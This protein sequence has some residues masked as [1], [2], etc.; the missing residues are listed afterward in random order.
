MEELLRETPEAEEYWRSSEAAR[1]DKIQLDR[2]RRSKDGQG[3]DEGTY[4]LLTEKM[5]WELAAKYTDDE[6]ARTIAV[7]NINMIEKKYQALIEKK[8]L[9]EKRRKEDG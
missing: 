2:N 6:S 8:M 7:E 4:R 5:S 1:D 9:E 3:R